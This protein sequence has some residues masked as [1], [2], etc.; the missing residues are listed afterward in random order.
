MERNNFKVIVT[1]YYLAKYLNEDK[2]FRL[3]KPRTEQWQTKT[4][5]EWVKPKTWKKKEN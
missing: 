2:M 3:Y 5:S 4:Q 1:S